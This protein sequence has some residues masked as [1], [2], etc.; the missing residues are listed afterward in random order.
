MNDEEKEC[1]REAAMIIHEN[2]GGGSKNEINDT[3]I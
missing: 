3:N 2:G 1:K